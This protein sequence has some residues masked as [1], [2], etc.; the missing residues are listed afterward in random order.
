[1]KDGRSEPPNMSWLPEPLRDQ[2]RRRTKIHQWGR[3]WEAWRRRA[4]IFQGYPS[5]S[6]VRAERPHRRPRPEFNPSRVY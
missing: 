1:M 2:V 4:C 6:R 5:E 3:M